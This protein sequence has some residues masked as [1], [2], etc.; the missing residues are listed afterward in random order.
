MNEENRKRKNEKVDLSA[1]AEWFPQD[2]TPGI[3]VDGWIALLN[4]SEVF[5]PSSLEIMK[6]MKDIG[7]IA[8]CKQ[9]SEK[10]GES[11]NFYNTGSS[12]LAKR[13]HKKTNCSLLARNTE[14]SRWWP[15]LYLGRDNEDRMVS[16]VYI[17][18][19]RPE[20]SDALDKV[21]LSEVPLSAI[22]EKPYSMSPWFWKISH[23]RTASTGISAEWKADCERRQVITMNRYTRG[24]SGSPITQGDRFLYSMRKGDFAYL[25]YGSEIKHL[26]QIIDD[27]PVQGQ[28]S[29]E[30]YERSYRIVKKSENSQYPSGAIRK[31]WTPNHNSTLVPIDA[32]DLKE[33]E[34]LILKPHFNSSTAEII[35]NAESRPDKKFW[36]LNGNPKMWDMETLSVGEVRDYTIF[37]ENGNARREYSAFIGCREGDVLIGYTGS[38]KKHICAIFECVTGANRQRIYFKKIIS[39]GNVIQ[40]ED[41]INDDILGEMA[42]MKSPQ[43]SLFPVTK[44]QFKRFIE[45][46]RERNSDIDFRDLEVQEEQGDVMWNS[47]YTRDDFLREVYISPEKYDSIVRLLKRKKNIIL[48]GAPGVGKTYIA[49]RLAYSMMGER[50]ESRIE[51]VQ[52]HQSYSYDDFVRGYK[53]NETSFE[54]KDGIF[55]SFCK[56]AFGNPTKDHFFIIDEINR[57]NLSKIFGELL[58]LIECDHRGESLKLSVGGEDFKVPDNV[59]IIGMMNTAD[60]SLAL[61]D[62][63]LRRRF[64][65]VEIEPGFKSVGFKKACEKLGNQKLDALIR[66]V[67]KLNSKIEKD[68]SLGKGFCIGHSYFCFNDTPCTDE[69]LSCIVK[70]DILPMLN[71]YWFDDNDSY[72]EWEREFAKWEEYLKV[73]SE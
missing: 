50:D 72:V 44:E 12:S 35:E 60:R 25:C 26:V 57:G 48:Q 68:S 13:V 18:K 53:P 22:T 15:I 49:K 34:D 24:L 11:T 37:N 23:G 58:M 56:K 73:E 42:A 10:Y 55:Y 62:Y 52:F 3:S 45:L 54:I 32:S 8:S 43:G 70:H 6:R 4:D 2:Y 30:W 16:G 21:D 36:F 47:K 46:A 38:P 29:D 27:E 63:A 69:S 40:R 17:W 14:N 5:S 41:I 33:F 59:Y 61:I 51:A 1:D 28:F 7:G 31:A 71:E 66:L 9:L 19:L 20:L 39:L 65:F 64:G 67:E